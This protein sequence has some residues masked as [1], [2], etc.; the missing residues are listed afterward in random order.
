VNFDKKSKLT[1][2][3]VTLTII[4][5][6]P[7]VFVSNSMYTLDLS[8]NALYIGNV[9]KISNN[10]LPKALLYDPKM[11]ISMSQILCQVQSPL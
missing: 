7:T 11:A 10:Y 1:L 5:S 2:I 9:A 6:L 8:N 3:L 4:F